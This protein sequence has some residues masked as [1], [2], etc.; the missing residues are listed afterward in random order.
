MSAR[1]PLIPRADIPIR[2]AQQSGSFASYPPGFVTSEQFGRCPSSGFIFEIDIR[3]GLPVVIAHDEAG[4][5]LLIERPRRRE[6]ASGRHHGIT[7]PNSVS[8]PIYF[9]KRTAS[10]FLRSYA[11]SCCASLD[12]IEGR[13]TQSY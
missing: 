12:C 11:L 6:A 10:P 8:E 13:P 9:Q 2:F 1:C 5:V 4:V 3:E 7:A